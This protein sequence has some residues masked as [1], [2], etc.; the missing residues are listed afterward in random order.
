M[1]AD[2]EQEVLV[3]GAADAADVDRVLLDNKDRRRFLGQAIGRCQ[4]GRPGA[5]DENV[6][7]ASATGLFAGKWHAPVAV[8]TGPYV[9]HSVPT[10]QRPASVRD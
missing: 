3:A 9:V 6:D 8:L 1:A 4:A 5:D 10:P 7:N 2:V